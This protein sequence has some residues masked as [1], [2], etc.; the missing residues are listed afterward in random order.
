M[1]ETKVNLDNVLALLNLAENSP[2]NL[3]NVELEASQST[4]TRSTTNKLVDG[5]VEGLATLKSFL[6]ITKMIQNLFP[7]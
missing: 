7:K 6:K 2:E 3:E 4:R 5:V 1:L